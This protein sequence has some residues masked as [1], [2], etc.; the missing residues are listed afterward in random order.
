MEVLVF[1]M[2]ARALL[3]FMMPETDNPLVGFVFVVTEF[4][5]TPVRVFCDRMDWFQGS[6]FDMPFLLTM[7]LLWL[8]EMLFSL[9]GG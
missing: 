9:V 7:L 1:M 8:I 5:I 6:L 2:L 4:C 3:S